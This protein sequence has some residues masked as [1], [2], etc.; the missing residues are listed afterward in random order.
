MRAPRRTKRHAGSPSALGTARSF[1]VRSGEHVDLD[2]PRGYYID[3]AY[4]ARAPAWP[5]RWLGVGGRPLYVTVAQWGLGCFE[6]YLAGEGESWLAGAAGAADYLL[7]KQETEGRHAG[8]WVHGFRYRHTYDLRP[9]WLSGMAQGECASLLVRVHAETEQGRYADAASRAMRPMGVA[10]AEGGVRAPLGEGLFLEEYPT[11]PPSLVLNGGIF[12]LWGCHD[13]GLALSDESAA[14]LFRE[15]AETLAANIDRFDTGYWSRYDLFPH[16]LINV[17]SSAYHRLHI[18]QL[19]AMSRL[20]PDDELTRAAARFERYANS[21]LRF[22]YAFARKV[23]FRIAVPRNKYMAHRL[24][25]R[26][27]AERD[28]DEPA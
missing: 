2:R 20:H 19:Q 18:A 15:G 13:I 28:G 1:P 6:R 14:A 3:F 27:R 12:A 5:P 24:P 7:E 23:A 10:S 22:A 21:R 16:P 11:S 25:W 17:A 4:K 26:H 9:P 8:G